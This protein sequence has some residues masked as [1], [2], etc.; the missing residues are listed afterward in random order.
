[1]HTNVH[2]SPGTNDVMEGGSYSSVF[3]CGYFYGVSVMK[4]AELGEAA[5]SSVSFRSAGGGGANVNVWMIDSQPAFQKVIATALRHAPDLVLGGCFV[6]PE[7]AL[8]CDSGLRPPDIILID[9]EEFGDEG[10]EAVRKL[11]AAFDGVPWIILTQAVE[12][13]S[14]S[15]AVCAGASG[16]LLKGSSLDKIPE[17][18]RETVRGGTLL[19]PSVARCVLEMFRRLSGARQNGGLTMRELSILDL[20]GQ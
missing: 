19:A 2:D 15:N 9:V 14:I 6:H 13:N 20:M 10:F 7:D 1:M 18:I 11:T 17:A 8:V 3:E 16:Y 12:E 4:D 5:G